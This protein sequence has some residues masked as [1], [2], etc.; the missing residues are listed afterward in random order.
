MAAAPYDLSQ[1]NGDEGLRF[2]SNMAMSGDRG[3]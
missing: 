3:I 2:R 1:F